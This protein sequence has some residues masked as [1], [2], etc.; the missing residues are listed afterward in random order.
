[1]VRAGIKE[2]HPAGIWSDMSSDGPV[3][4]TLVVVLDR[5]VGTHLKSHRESSLLT[6]M[7]I[8]QKNLPNKKK[9]G[10]QDPYAVAR[11]AKEAKRT[12]TDVRGGQVPRW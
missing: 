1:M 7:D 11:L 2:A 6:W 8:V 12:D 3:I 5:A 9:I 10:K 4:G